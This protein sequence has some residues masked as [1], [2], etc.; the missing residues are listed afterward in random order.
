MAW[1]I[2]A[3]H[4]LLAEVDAG[5]CPYTRSEAGL[6]NAVGLLGD[7]S[8]DP[9][10]S[11]ETEHLRCCLIRDIRK[12]DMVT[13]VDC[14]RENCPPPGQRELFQIVTLVNQNVE[15]VEDDV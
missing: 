6:I 4:K 5:L 2:A 3:D 15:R 10:G 7:H 9:V 1:N 11:H 13:R 14:R 12:A 8:F